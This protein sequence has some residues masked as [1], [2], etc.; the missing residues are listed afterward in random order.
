MS[1]KAPSSKLSPPVRATVYVG[2]WPEIPGPRVSRH[3]N[4]YF[5]P[6]HGH[7]YQRPYGGNPR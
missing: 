6:H 1:S 4:G 5:L 3:P 2:R 7:S